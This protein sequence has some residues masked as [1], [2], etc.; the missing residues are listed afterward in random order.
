[1]RDCIELRTAGIEDGERI[2]DNDN[3]NEDMVVMMMVSSKSRNGTALL[4]WRETER[5]G[6][7]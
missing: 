7:C 2:H 1:M 3:D 5:E 4:V 6:C